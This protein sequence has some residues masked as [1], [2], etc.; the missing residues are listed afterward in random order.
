M[1]PLF[2][3]L[4]V[5]TTLG[6]CLSCHKYPEDPFISFRR[7]FKRIE[8]TWNI[9]S[10]QIWGKEHSHDFESLLNPNTLTNCSI[11]FQ[12]NSNVIDEGWWKFLDRNN[13]ILFPLNSN[14]NKYQFDVYGKPKT[15]VDFL[16]DINDIDS[17]FYNLFFYQQ[18]TFNRTPG[19]NYGFSIVELYGQNF[20]ISLNGIDIYFK[21]Q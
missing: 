16:L 3:I 15:T 2:K 21:K 5:L 8:G 11:S 1:K 18:K 12:S 20:H 10:Y 14:I 7:P 17:T 4:F 9:T 13:N 19:R 6:L